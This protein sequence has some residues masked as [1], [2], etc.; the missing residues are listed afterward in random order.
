MGKNPKRNGSMYTYIYIHTYI[1][2]TGVLCCM[3]EINTI[4]LVSNIPIKMFLR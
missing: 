3:P 1:D 2:I 4:L